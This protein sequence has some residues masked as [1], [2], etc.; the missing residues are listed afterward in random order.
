M[1]TKLLV[2]LAFA[3]IALLVA[4]DNGD[5]GEGRTPSVDVSPRVT[6]TVQE[7]ETPTPGTT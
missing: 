3:S 6:V 2:A 1:S 7:D 4:C 5:E